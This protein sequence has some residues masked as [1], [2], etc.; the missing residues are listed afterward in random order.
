MI[1]RTHLPIII[2][3]SHATGK[4]A[5][6]A[7]LA[8]AAAAIGADGLIIEVHN[9]PACAVCDGPQSLTPAAFDAL[10]SQIRGILPSAYR[11]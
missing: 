5:Y 1:M 4:S 9:N 8:L 6:V 7:P 11:Y 10:A 2:G 3:P